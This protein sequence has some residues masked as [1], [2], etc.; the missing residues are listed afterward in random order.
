M[1]EHIFWS[2]FIVSIILFILILEYIHIPKHHISDDVK[3]EILHNG[4]MHFTLLERA[5][6]IQK[7]GLV[8]GKR[9]AMNIFEKNMVWL[10]INNAEEF[11]QKYDIVHSKG[12]R[13]AYNAVVIFKDIEEKQIRHMRYRKKDMAVVH[14]GILSASKVIIKNLE[15]GDSEIGIYKE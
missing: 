15:Q 10:Y 4:L 2:I 7:D 14:K 12:D 11:Q 3:K 13:R 6:E 9:K 5:Y 8:P 1:E